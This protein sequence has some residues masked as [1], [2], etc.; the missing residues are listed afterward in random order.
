MARLSGFLKR[1][2]P[3]VREEIGR[4]RQWVGERPHLLNISKDENTNT[5]MV[6]LVNTPVAAAAPAGDRATEPFVG[7]ED[8]VYFRA[9]RPTAELVERARWALD[10][11]VDRRIGGGGGGATAQV[12]SQIV[13]AICEA[14]VQ[15]DLPLP[16]Q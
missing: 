6:S 11:L 10:E 8:W 1:A 12:E 3:E 13:D 9:D 7:V 16:Q 2:A 15:D 14:L 4:L 5:W